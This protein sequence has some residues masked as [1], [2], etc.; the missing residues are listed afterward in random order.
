MYCTILTT[1]R[2]DTPG[3][4]ILYRIRVTFHAARAP[5]AALPTPTRTG[6]KH[7]AKRAAKRS[8]PTANIRRDKTCISVLFGHLSRR[9]DC[10]HVAAHGS[11]SRA[12]RHTTVNEARPATR[13]TPS[14]LVSCAP[15]RAPALPTRPH[16]RR[17]R[18]P[19]HSRP[20]PLLGLC[21]LAACASARSSVVQLARWQMSA[22]EP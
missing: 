12:T 19:R 3:S 16:P 5:P 20:P 9:P 13:R 2:D 15:L 11:R 6:T 7:E 8:T 10:R 21:G 17:R 14:L 22:D 18:P 1:V 4:D